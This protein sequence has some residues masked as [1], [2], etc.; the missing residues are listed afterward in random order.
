MHGIRFSEDFRAG[1]FKFHVADIVVIAT[2]VVSHGRTWVFV[3]LSGCVLEW[4][5][6]GIAVT[7][8]LGLGCHDWADLSSVKRLRFKTNRANCRLVLQ[9]P[10]STMN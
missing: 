7:W 3:Y 2:R 6:V 5:C 1:I 8:L 4:L 10:V 9:V